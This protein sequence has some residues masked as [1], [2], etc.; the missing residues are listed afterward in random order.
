MLSRRSLNTVVTNMDKEEGEEDTETKL[1][2]LSSIFTNASQEALLDI[3]IKAD[4]NVGRAIDL[5]LDT[6]TQATLH[7]EGPRPPKRPRLD[8][9]SPV[10][11]PSSGSKDISS[12][13]KWTGSAEPPRKVLP[14]N[15][16]LL[17]GTGAP[18]NSPPLPSLTNRFINSMY[19]TP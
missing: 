17:I 1:A 7:D 5:H 14:E 4:G 3:L 16:S 13:L 15:G 12:I 9:K 6:A 19:V 11:Q 8:S 2:L 18:S 10:K